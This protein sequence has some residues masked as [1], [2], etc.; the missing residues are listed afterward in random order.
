MMK[1]QFQRRPKFIRTAQW[2]ARQSSLAASILILMMMMIMFVTVTTPAAAAAASAVVCSGD[3]I[4]SSTV[5]IMGEVGSCSSWGGSALECCR[6]CHQMYSANHIARYI[7]SS[8]ASAESQCCCY[9]QGILKE[10]ENATD[11]GSIFYRIR[12]GATEEL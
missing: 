1:A 8:S 7:P 11:D 12:Q 6:I 9:Y 3:P 4:A 10:E 5:T 2:I